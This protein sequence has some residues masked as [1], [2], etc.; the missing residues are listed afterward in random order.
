MALIICNPT[1]STSLN[2]N[3]KLERFRQSKIYRISHTIVC[4]GTG[5]IWIAENDEIYSRKRNIVLVLY[6]LIHTYRA[7][8]FLRFVVII[9]LYKTIVFY[10]GVFL[11]FFYSF[12]LKEWTNTIEFPS[13]S[14]INCRKS[15]DLRQILSFLK[16]VDPMKA[17]HILWIV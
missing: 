6:S 2:I 17:I 7:Y 13:S 5:I 16:I 8:A 12:G 11:R 10:V 3:L 15:F 9:L 14:S 4:T 1:N